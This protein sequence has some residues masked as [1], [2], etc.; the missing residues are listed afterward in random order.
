[1]LM[2]ITLRRHHTCTRRAWTLHRKR[3]GWA[4]RWRKQR[5]LTCRS[6]TRT[7][8]ATLTCPLPP[9]LHGTPSDCHP[10]LTRLEVI[11]AGSSAGMCWVTCEQSSASKHGALRGTHCADLPCFR[12]LEDPER[13]ETPFVSSLDTE[14]GGPNT[15]LGGGSGPVGGGSNTADSLNGLVGALPGLSASAGRSAAAAASSAF[16]TGFLGGLPPPASGLLD[17]PWGQLTGLALPVPALQVRAVLGVCCLTAHDIFSGDASTGLA[18]PISLSWGMLEAHCCS[19]A[20]GV[21]RVRQSSRQTSSQRVRSPA[22]EPSM[23]LCR[24]RSWARRL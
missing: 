5:R 21:C 7:W 10:L 16:G 2:G 14:L 3:S 6:W 13:A 8:L 15:P 23:L 11:T 12:S 24:R 17:D 20:T 9:C 19:P 4:A 1:M 22:V 18:K